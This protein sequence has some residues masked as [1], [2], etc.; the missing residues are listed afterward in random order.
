MSSSPN[1]KQKVELAFVFNITLLQSVVL[2]CVGVGLVNVGFSETL[3]YDR[4]IRVGVALVANLIWAYFMARVMN[5][6]RF[7]IARP[8]EGFAAAYATIKGLAA[9]GGKLVALGIISYL[10]AVAVNP[11]N[12]LQNIVI[13][14]GALLSV[15][16]LFV[17]LSVLIRYFG[18][19]EHHGR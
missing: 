8:V 17:F 4:L 7:R 18:Y 2:F 10:L 11:D 1:E 3:P 12:V 19:G 9:L 6:P 14:A 16:G 13:V 5:L 15:V